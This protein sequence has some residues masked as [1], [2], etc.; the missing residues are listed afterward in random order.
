MKKFGK[1][2][3]EEAS[4]KILDVDLEIIDGEVFNTFAFN[5][6]LVCDTVNLKYVTSGER[7]FETVQHTKYYRT[8]DS[9]RTKSFSSTPLAAHCTCRRWELCLHA[10]RLILAPCQL[11]IVRVLYVEVLAYYSN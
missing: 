2:D 4:I 1:R 11:A 3:T 5:Y 8:Q 10:S 9:T 7:N 6:K